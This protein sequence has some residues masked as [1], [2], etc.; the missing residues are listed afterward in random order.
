MRKLYTLLVFLSV[1][2]FA[3]AQNFEFQ[4][5]NLFGIQGYDLDSLNQGLKYE[6]FDVDGDD[7]LD[8]ITAGLSPLDTEASSPQYQLRFFLSYQE[9]VGD[10]FEPEFA[11]R[12]NLFEQFVFPDPGSFL[13]PAAGDINNDGLVDFVVSSDVD[14][15]D[16]QYLQFH[17]QQPDGSFEIS[18]CLDWDLPSFPPYSLFFPELID[19][20]NDGDLDILL[21]GYYGSLNEDLEVQEENT[22]LYAKNI[23]TADNPEFLG[24]YPDPYGLIADEQSFVGAGDLDQDG[25]VDL[26]NL[27]LVDSETRVRIIYNIADAGDN[28]FFQAPIA[29]SVGIPPAEEEEASYLFPTLVDMDADGDLDLFLPTVLDEDFQLRYFENT[30]CAADALMPFVEANGAILSCNEGQAEYRW[31]D[32]TDNTLLAT[33]DD[34]SYEVPFSGSYYVAIA[35][36]AGCLYY[37]ECIEVQLSS[38]GELPDSPVSY[39]PNPAKDRLFISSK[40]SLPIKRIRL[41]DV[42]GKVVLHKSNWKGDVLMLDGLSNGLYILSIESDGISIDEKLLIT[43]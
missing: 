5:A 27:A 1:A 35:N 8:L 15:Y 38:I 19:L 9:N 39:Y 11:E 17:I 2:C 25:D 26:F 21:G 33:T 30:N 28:P 16:I 13:I 32:C 36:D 37:S 41:L 31:Y 18:N 34:N 29:P 6:F 10:K 3:Q 40:N 22:Y 4:G 20:D 23:G 14:I 12:T 24:W 7:D 43:K 42:N